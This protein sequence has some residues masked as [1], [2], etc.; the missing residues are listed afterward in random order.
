MFFERLDCGYFL[1]IKNRQC[2]KVMHIYEAV[3][4]LYEA[5]TGF[6]LFRIVLWGEQKYGGRKA[7]IWID[8]E[9]VWNSQISYLNSG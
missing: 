5:V 3:Y 2:T 9:R 7:P 8:C 1:G 4:L 6:Y